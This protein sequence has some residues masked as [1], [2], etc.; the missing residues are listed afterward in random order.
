MSKGATGTSLAQDL[1]GMGLGSTQ[2]PAADGFASPTMSG[3]GYNWYGGQPLI[4]EGGYYNQMAQNMA[5][6]SY[7]P[8]G[9][10]FYS[11][12]GS[13]PTASKGASPILV[14]APT[15]AP[16]AQ[17]SPVQSVALQG[18]APQTQ[19]SVPQATAS[20][21]SMGHAMA[22]GALAALIGRIGR[23]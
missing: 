11:G 5:G 10:N 3:Y 14:G 16:P 21:P 2:M 19:L 17:S 13:G 15:Q 4:P 1:G 8:Q 23:F 12:N 7:A 18:A 22:P 9:A 6:P 20:A